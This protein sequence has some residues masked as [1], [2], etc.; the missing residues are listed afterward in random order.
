MTRP[1][2]FYR[3]W[4]VWVWSWSLNIIR[5]WPTGCCCN[6]VKKKLTE[7]RIWEW[8]WHYMEKVRDCRSTQS[9]CL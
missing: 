4:C 9:A 5:P 1:E 7:H 8:R 6:V 2:E 3:L